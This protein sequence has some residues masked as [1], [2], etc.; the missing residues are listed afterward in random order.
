MG[1]AEN[2]ETVRLGLELWNQHDWRCHDVLHADDIVFHGGPEGMDPTLEGMHER[3]AEIWEA[4]PDSRI[5]LF[6]QV[7]EGD[8]FTIHYKVTGTHEGELLGAAPTGRR[9]EFEVI[10]IYRFGSEG[11][12]VEAWGLIDELSFLRQLGLAPATT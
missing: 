2:K 10:W 12:I 4:M 3:V 11:K 9:I 6:R 5:E 1:I 8:L 7:A